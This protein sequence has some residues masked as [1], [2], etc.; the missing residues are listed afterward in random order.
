M[1]VLYKFI[2]T[3]GGWHG[4]HICALLKQ[5]DQHFIQFHLDV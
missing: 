4:N 3:N 1:H 5:W 2:I